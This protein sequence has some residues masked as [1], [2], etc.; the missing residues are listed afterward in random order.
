MRNTSIIHKGTGETM[1]EK[2]IKHK[3]AVLPF[4]GII[5]AIFIFFG[6]SASSSKTSQTISTQ[7]KYDSNELKT[8][9]EVMEN[10]IQSFLNE[11]NGISDVSVILTVE[12]SN[13]TVYATQG[14]N[15]DYVIIK[16]AKGNENAIPLTEISAKIR[17]IAVVCDY[18]GDEKL[19]MTVIELLSAVF[20]VGSNRISIL[21][22]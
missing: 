11:I 19:K 1:I 3:N 5:L 4:L 10:K 12:S 18:S 7:A 17:G 20:D 13:E 16:D 22:A 8:Y 2:I 21:P 14:V 6:D 9:T 15:S